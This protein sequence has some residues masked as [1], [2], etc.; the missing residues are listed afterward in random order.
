MSKRQMQ[1]IISPELNDGDHQG[2]CETKEQLLTMV[3]AWADAEL[4]DGDDGDDCWIQ[5]IDREKYPALVVVD[6]D[7]SEVTNGKGD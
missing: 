4:N 1:F 7:E 6:E 3:G 5:L 2:I